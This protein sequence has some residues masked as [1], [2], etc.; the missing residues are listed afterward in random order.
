MARAARPKEEEAAPPL[1]PLAPRRLPWLQGTLQQAARWSRG[2]ALLIESSGDSG[3]WDLALLLGFALLCE[4][5]DAQK[6]CGHCRACTLCA[7]RTHPDL[8]LALPQTLDAQAVVESGK[9]PSEEISIASVRSLIDFC[10]RT[11]SLGSIKV[12]LLHPAER[13]SQPAANALLKT[14][15]EPPGQTRIILCT[16]AP[17]ALSATILSRCQRLHLPQPEADL[18]LQWLSEQSHDPPAQAKALLAA[19]GGNPLSALALAEQGI[20]AKNWQSLPEAA[21]AADL[22]FFKDWTLELLVDALQK[23][24]L[25]AQMALYGQPARFFPGQSL[26]SAEPL[27]LA[28]WSRDLLQ[29]RRTAR[30]PFNQ[31]LARHALLLQC[32]QVF[33]R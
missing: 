2:H 4:G 24:C 9:K 14:L 21:L 22:D 11:A 3:Q 6:P 16:Q 30:H 15:E 10:E 26:P 18:A 5:N 19:A 29:A 27:A 20:S 13:M 8:H 31:P 17:G 32:Q 28:R 1:E 7:A 25:D 23:L 12:A 33:G